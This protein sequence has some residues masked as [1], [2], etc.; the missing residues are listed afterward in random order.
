[1]LARSERVAL[2]LRVERIARRVVR[3]GDDVSEIEV[4]MVVGEA[5]IFAGWKNPC[6][7]ERLARDLGIPLGP[8]ARVEILVAD[9]VDVHRGGPAVRRGM[10]RQLVLWRAIPAV[11]GD[12]HRLAH[13][14]T[15]A[16][17]HGRRERYRAGHE[18]RKE[19]ERGGLSDVRLDEL[20]EMEVRREL[21]L[22]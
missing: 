17:E 3:H 10:A 11:G 1:M 13:G 4:E 20:P 2:E 19:A 14:L 9:T 22:E 5:A 7:G 8:L 15:K 6:A 16:L 18:A 21:V 12:P